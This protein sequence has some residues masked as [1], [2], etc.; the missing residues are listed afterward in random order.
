MR[1]RSL[2]LLEIL[3]LCIIVTSC[4]RRSFPNDTG[5]NPSEQLAIYPEKATEAVM[6]TF[7]FNDMMNID[8]EEAHN[9][10]NN[11][12][13]DD[14]L[15]EKGHIAVSEAAE[16]I[17]YY[18]GSILNTSEFS[19]E[20]L[21]SLF[22]IEELD[23]E[24][25]DRITG[26]SYK[27]GDDILPYS[28]LRY[29]RLLHMDFD[30]LTR[31]GEMIVNKAIAEDVLDIFRELYK[32]EYPIERMLLIDEYG[33]DDLKSMSDNNSSAFNYR[34]IEGTSRRSMH[35]YGLAIDIN[36]LYNPYVRTIDGELDILPN[37]ATDYVDR[38]KD[39]I[40][41]IRK[42]DIIYNAFVSRGFTWG[43]EWNNSKD[44]QHF[45]KKLGLISN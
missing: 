18:A 16:P 36:P 19:K 12:A 21:D 45:E 7:T 35:S 39:N 23:Q 34:L 22:Y 17:E 14:I 5:Q 42:D 25:I 8:V 4:S 11:M 1:R 31:M 30:G 40:Y 10:E 3:L 43:G 15:Y 6:E 41:Y 20:I 32:L 9:E 44:Y 37:N 29:I 2:I 38:D 27:E 26:L 24:I 13:I 33:A 28:D